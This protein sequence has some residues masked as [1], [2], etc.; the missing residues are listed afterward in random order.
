MFNKQTPIYIPFAVARFESKSVVRMA[1][2]I[3]ASDIDGAFDVSLQLPD[4]EKALVA[5][6]LK[7]K[8]IV[9][10]NERLRQ[11][12]LSTNLHGEKKKMDK[13]AEESTANKLGQSLIAL[14]FLLIYWTY[15]IYSD[16]TSISFGGGPGGYSGPTRRTWD[17]ALIFASAATIVSLVS[18]LVNLLRVKSAS[19]KRG[20]ITS[21]V[22]FFLSFTILAYFLNVVFLNDY[23]G[24]PESTTFGW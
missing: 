17:Q 21:V 11:F 24:A 3:G 20:K 12:G 19:T 10:F 14:S 18:M 8:K 13:A 2:G 9:E 16:G 22:L 5:Y 1:G 7:G 23:N 15:N 6:H 4:G